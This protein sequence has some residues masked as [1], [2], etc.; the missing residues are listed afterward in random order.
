[1]AIKGEKE[2][3]PAW[4]LPC[5]SPLSCVTSVNYTATKKRKLNF[6]LQQTKLKTS[7]EL[8]YLQVPGIR[9]RTNR[10]LCRMVKKKKK[11]KN[12]RQ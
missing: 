2:P 9:K 7:K 11:S 5:H 1:M 10:I 3:S 6:E 4:P 8:K 12:T